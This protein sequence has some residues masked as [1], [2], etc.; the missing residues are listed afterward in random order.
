[1]CMRKILLLVMLA[2]FLTGCVVHVRPAVRH[3]PQYEDEYQDYQGN[4]SYMGYYYDRIVFIQGIPYHVDEERHIHQIPIKYRSHFVSYPYDRISSP[5]AFSKDNE[6][7]DGYR[8]S[9]IV[10]FDGTPF[11]VNDDRS[12]NPLPRHL[13]PRFVYRPSMQGKQPESENR[14]PIHIRRD[15]GQ[16]NQP[17]VTVQPQAPASHPLFG[18]QQPEQVHKS[19]PEQRGR[20]AAPENRREESNQN[21]ILLKKQQAAG[22]T[23]T[24]EQSGDAKATDK[25]IEKRQDDKKKQRDRRKD[26]QRDHD[27]ADETNENDSSA[28]EI[29]TTDNGKRKS[30]KEERGN[31]HNHD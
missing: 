14:R 11:Q 25:N 30:R 24:K 4:P 18:R 12:A 20:M 21:K 10:Y 2:L 31:G 16:K 26:K 29:D 23:S 27:E 8:M 1:M 13:H 28:T 22:I 5:L 7:R 19:P 6:V 17:R 3:S 15:H 9:R